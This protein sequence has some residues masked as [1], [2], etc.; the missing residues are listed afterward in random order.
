MREKMIEIPTAEGRMDAFV[1]HP[2][3]GGPFPA[4]V[5]FMDVWGLRE[6]LFDVARRVATVGYH[7]TVPNFWYRRGKVRFEY[8]NEKGQ[9]RSLLDLPQEAQDEIHANMTLVTDPMAMEDTRLLLKFLESEPVRRGPKGSVG[10]CLGGRLGLLA[11]GLYPD[12]FRATASL[13]G[14]RLVSDS[15][16]SPHLLTKKFRGEIYC[17]FAEHDPWAPPATIATLKDLLASEK[18]VGYRHL[19]HAGAHHGYALPDRDIFDKAA[20]NRDWENIFA[21]FKRQLN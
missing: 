5:I 15:P 12:E 11:A 8:R 10:Y 7:C 9:M 13:H 19:L 21:M 2:E 1:T 6:E 14:T 18:N 16:E 20:A 3:E 17:G 4:V